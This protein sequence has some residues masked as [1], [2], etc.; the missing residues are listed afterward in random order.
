M[1]APSS[2]PSP[3]VS[4]F[5]PDSN[6]RYNKDFIILTF[7]ASVEENSGLWIDKASY[8]ADWLP[9][10]TQI[11]VAPLHTAEDG[12]DRVTVSLNLTDI[13]DGK[14]VIRVYVFAQGKIVE[15]LNWY[16]FETLGNSQTEFT[17]DTTP[18]NISV[19]PIKDET[20]AQSEGAEVPLVFTLNES[21]SKISYALDGQVNV[22]VNGNT[23]L[24]GLSDG[25][26]EVTVFAWDVYG[27]VGCSE[28]VTFTVAGPESF[29]TVPAVAFSTASIATVCASLLLYFRRRRKEV[30]QG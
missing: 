6:V 13:P 10:S 18:P 12:S 7:N 14:H 15:P 5:S 16:T 25:K 4:I 30:K 9:N 20:H 19:F 2:A 11:D 21:A 3:V 1:M 22:T 29:P 24:T 17:I 8:A 27:N 23:T 26:H 28:T